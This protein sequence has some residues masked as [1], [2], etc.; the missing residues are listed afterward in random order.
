MLS[1]GV[2]SSSSIAGHRPFEGRTELHV[3]ELIQH[4][5]P[6]A[7]GER[8]PLIS[9]TDCES[10]R[11]GSG[12][13]FSVDELNRRRSQAHSPDDASRYGRFCCGDI[14]STMTAF[15]RSSR[16]SS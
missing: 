1:F 14:T 3:L 13:S 6:A 12:P 5:E 15:D 11:Q 10:A 9:N 16:A 4:G 8:F 7:L 2:C